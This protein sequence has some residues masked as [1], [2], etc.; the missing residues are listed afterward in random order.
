MIKELFINLFPSNK[1]YYGF[2]G[3][4]LLFV[5]SYQIP[6]LFPLGQ[7]VLFMSCL[8]F[9]LSAIVLFY[10]K[11]AI[12]AERHTYELLSLGDENEIKIKIY[13]NFPFRVNIEVIDEL[14]FQLQN[15]NF[16]L[17]A[18]LDKKSSGILQY[19]IRPL[20]RGDYEFGDILV[21]V[22][23]PFSFC[24]R[25]FKIKTQGNKRVYPSIIQMKIYQLKVLSRISRLE[26]SKK[27]RRIGQS[28]EFEQI[29]NY[30]EGDDFRHINWKATSRATGGI[31]IN[32]F[33]D[34]K[35]QAVY[36]IIDKS[37]NMKMPFNGLSLMDYAINSSLVISNSALLKSD[38]AGLI[39]FSEKIDTAIK[40]VNKPGQ[41]SLILNALYN[42]K[43]GQHESNYEL[44]LQY[45]TQHVKQRSLL[46]LYT[47]FETT[48]NLYRILPV[49]RRL[50][51]MHL[52]VVVMF[53]NSE[54]FKL[55][56]E[57][58]QNT[59][60]LYTAVVAEKFIYQKS[61]IEKEL[62]ING[63]KSILTTPEELTIQTVNKYLEIKSQGLI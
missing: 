18:K 54:I 42:E 60:E 8:W 57:R 48:H 62:K 1:L 50:N 4:I 10:L 11:T 63:I 44:L 9:G 29:R 58:Y 33:E 55:S 38:R 13:N 5:I 35:A 40:S 52:L 20:S 30:V 59:P 2:A 47:N 24:V 28:Y 46:F 15:R 16:K 61:L 19:S 34:E 49:L 25:R 39:T 26:G 31:K 21:Y 51:R 7:V 43:E 32:Q 45:V 12:L 27:I 56:K 23:F 37:R 14:P 53:Q 3:S 22:S 41:L 17:E 36:C 6:I